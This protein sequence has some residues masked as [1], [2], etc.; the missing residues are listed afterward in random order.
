[1]SISRTF[2]YYNLIMNLISLCYPMG[3]GGGGY[4]SGSKVA[5]V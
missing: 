3:G 1:M 2:S 5:G 4:F